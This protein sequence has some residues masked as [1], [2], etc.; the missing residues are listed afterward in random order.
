MISIN[1]GLVLA[2]FD[3]NMKVLL[4]SLTLFF[5]T[6]VIN[7]SPALF[8]LA[9]SVLMSGS[10]LALVCVLLYRALR[11]GPKGFNT[12]DFFRIPR[13]EE[14]STPKAGSV[15]KEVVGHES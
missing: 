7:L 2:F 1:K 6:V 4:L 10:A 9:L 3:H 13:P 15:M 11:K 14:R 5:V 8:I 12:Y